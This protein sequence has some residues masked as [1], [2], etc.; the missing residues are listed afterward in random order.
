MTLV[1]TKATWAA[2]QA[3]AVATYPDE[4]CGMV[5]DRNGS[6]ETAPVTNIQNDLHAQDPGQFPRTAR[7]AYTMGPEA[8]PILIAAERGVLCLRA[9]Y[10]SHP[11]HDAYFSAEDRMQA[12]GGWDEPNYPDAAQI[13]ISVR[14]REVLAA[15]AFAWD[16]AQRDFA[17]IALT[18]R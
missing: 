16:A 6:E 11:D 1:I 4:C 15:K 9:I 12:L 3:H 8:A 14:N 2:L 7:T 10:H 17:E 18:I 5:V 13:V